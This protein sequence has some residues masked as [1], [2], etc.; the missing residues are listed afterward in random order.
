MQ[1]SGSQED[2]LKIIWYLERDQIKAT[3]KAVA[4]RHQVKPPTALNMF[5]QLANMDLIHYGKTYGA[6]LSSQGNSLARK[7]IRKHRL[8][9]TFLEKVLNM[10]EHLLHEEAERLEHVISDNLM[11]RIDSYLGFPNSDPHG[12]PIPSWDEQVKPVSISDVIVGCSFRVQEVSLNADLVKFYD[13]RRFTRGTT[14]TLQDKTPDNSAYT[15]TNG[16]LFL[17]L[18][19]DMALKIKVIPYA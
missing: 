17:A 1:L 3:P 14:W 19:H 7:L 13:Q 8:L 16:K 4:D 11:Y 12:S 6:R 18:N 9:E 10:D 2:Y 15:L 5:R